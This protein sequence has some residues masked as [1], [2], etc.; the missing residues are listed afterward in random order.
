MP[1]KG[2]RNSLGSRIKTDSA[3]AAAPAPRRAPE[4]P[5]VGAPDP[6]PP[7]EMSA[8]DLPRATL[9]RAPPLATLAHDLP[10]AVSDSDLRPARQVA[11]ATPR[12][13]VQAAP[14]PRRAVRRR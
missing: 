3:T 10:P 6:G 7:P 13:K 5:E 14:L 12:P 8:Q 1:A 11:A 2:P 9:V 4:R